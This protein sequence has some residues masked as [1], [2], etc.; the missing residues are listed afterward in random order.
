MLDGL[1]PAR[2]RL[3]LAVT[4]LVV[5][6]VLGAVVAVVVG[7][8]APVDPVA[9]GELGPV[10]LLP[11]YGGAAGGL[12]PLAA[13]LRAEG[14]TASIIEPPGDGRG[15]LREHAALVA[16][17]ARRAVAG[18]APSVDVV[19]YSAGG[20]V[21]RYFVAELGGDALTRR[22][23]TLASPHH[24]TDLAATAGSLGAGTCPEACQQLRP[25]SD[26]LVDLGRGDETPAGPLWAALWTTDDSTVVPPTSGR[27]EGAVD[28]AVQDV[29][30][31]LVL[32]HADVPA[33]PAVVAMALTELGTAAP[34]V[35][36]AEVC[37]A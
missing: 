26:L 17:A 30:P 33:D 5:L 36:G 11:G 21:A 15:D 3:V 34:A 25:D 20:V 14:R 10:L 1:A 29:C 23:L 7:R 28:F 37:S 31:G 19:G 9:Q 6:A 2:R 35:P 22:V 8:D 18:G 4:G 12:E 13:A 27:L 32:D 16:D 24:G